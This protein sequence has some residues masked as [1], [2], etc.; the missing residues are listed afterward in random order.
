MEDQ[1]MLR[2]LLEI[3]GQA[4]V[5]VNDA[6]TEADRRIKEAEEQS[7]HAYDAEYQKYITELETQ[8]HKEQE[9]VKAEYSAALDQYRLSLEDMPRDKGAFSAYVRSL[10]LDKK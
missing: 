5:L 4:A 1:N 3:E 6:Q 10:L 8:Y 7:R 2:H 9:A